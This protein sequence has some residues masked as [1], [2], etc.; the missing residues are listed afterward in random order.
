MLK[1]WVWRALREK[2]DLE[3]RNVIAEHRTRYGLSPDGAANLRAVLLKKL[4][5]LF[6][7][8]G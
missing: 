2:A 5:R 1:R 8:K 3:I 6:G 7:I 4:D